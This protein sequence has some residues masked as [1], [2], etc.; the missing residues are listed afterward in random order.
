MTHWEIAESFIV[1]AFFAACA[2][3]GYFVGGLVYLG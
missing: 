2:L 1:G 3:A